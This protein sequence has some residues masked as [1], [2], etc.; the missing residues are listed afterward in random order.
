MPVFV[1]FPHAHFW[2]M[3]VYSIYKIWVVWPRS[4]QISGARSPWQL[5]FVW[6]GLMS[7]DKTCFMHPYGTLEFWGSS[8]ISGKFV[9]PWFCL[10]SMLLYCAATVLCCCTVQQ[11]FYVAVLCSCCSML[12]YCAAAVLCCCTVQR[13][14]Y[15]SVS[16]SNCSMLLYCAAA[17]LCCCTVQQLFSAWGMNGVALL[18]LL[19]LLLLEEGKST[20]GIG[21]M[22]KVV[23]GQI[24]CPT[25]LIWYQWCKDVRTAPC[26]HVTDSVV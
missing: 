22:W 2:K 13:L 3:A 6:L 16:C 4:A 1:L 12:L 17:V 21:R 14:F 9:H 18:K 15:F 11:L 24:Y 7:V 19:T 20:W 26:C 8:L 5:N 10:C 25:L 23:M